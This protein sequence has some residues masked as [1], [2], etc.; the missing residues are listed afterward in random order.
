M[1]IARC[2][3]G[4]TVRAAESYAGSKVTCPKCRQPITIPIPGFSPTVESS[5]DV[6]TIHGPQEN[7]PFG[8]RPAPGG[9]ERVAATPVRPPVPE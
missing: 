4:Q 7:K 1:I 5:G 3:C 6:I 9:A 2:S 8:L